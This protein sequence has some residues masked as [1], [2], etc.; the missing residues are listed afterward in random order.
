MTTNAW[1]SAYVVPLGAFAVAIVA[2]AGGIIGQA[3]ARSVKA[4]QRMTMLARGI[5]LAE[6]E[7]VLSSDREE[8]GQRSVS[9]PMRRLGNTRRAASVLISVGFGLIFFF[10]VLALV[11]ATRQVLAGAA[12]GLIPLMVGLG[13]LA[14]YQVQKREMARF[15]LMVGE[16]KL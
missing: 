4:Q 9:D 6:I 16:E 7:A 8:D 1:D 13:F 11:L 15:G 12:V 10:V 2:I 3:H 5:P 14:D